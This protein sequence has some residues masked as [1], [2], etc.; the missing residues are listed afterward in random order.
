GCVAFYGVYDFTDRHGQYRNP[1]LGR[2]LE[3]WVMKRSLASARDA[4]EKASPLSRIHAEAPPFFVVHGD[5]ATLG[6]APE[7][8]GFG[9]ARPTALPVP[10]VYAEIPGAQHAFEIF[11]SLRTTFVVHGVAR[12]LAWLYSAYLVE[13]GVPDARAAS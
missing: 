13:H 7:A 5:R 8:R 2:L 12:F 1:G 11:P 3:R 9:E 6:P 4:F 10:V